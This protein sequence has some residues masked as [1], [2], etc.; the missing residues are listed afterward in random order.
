MSDY[1]MWFH[2]G[3]KFIT[4]KGVKTFFD[5]NPGDVINVYNKDGELEE[6][7]VVQS[8]TMF[9]TFNVNTFNLGGNESLQPNGNLPDSQF[10]TKKEV[11]TYGE[12]LWLMYTGRFSN[13]IN[14]GDSL[15]VAP[16]NI[17][18]LCID[19]KCPE[20]FVNGG[21]LAT[22]ADYIAYIAEDI[23]EV[24][25]YDGVVERGSYI[26]LN[27]DKYNNNKEFLNSVGLYGTYYKYKPSYIPIPG[28]LSNQVVCILTGDERRARIT[29]TME[30]NKC[31]DY[32]KAD[33]FEGYL[34]FK[35][36]TVGKDGKIYIREYDSRVAKFV[37]TCSDY[38]GY[39]I[40][41]LRHVPAK[42]INAT[43]FGTKE[44]YDK[45]GHYHDESTRVPLLNGGK[46]YIR[47]AE[48]YEIILE[49]KTIRHK[50]RRY[51]FTGRTTEEAK[52][53]LIRGRRH[54]MKF[55]YNIKT[56]SGSFILANGIIAITKPFEPIV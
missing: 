56:E 46:K 25:V 50:N 39:R 6:G 14:I 34:F 11:R 23:G 29:N 30:W 42:Y 48:Y 16:K 19:L 12:D 18:N 5:V 36:H 7:T 49:P 3:T 27:E 54:N 24:T 9:N 2:K 32:Y 21:V 35:G 43:G 33:A 8:G 1:P 55:P 22:G 52:D 20:W 40:T 31:P 17:N 38:A 41:L 44:H 51:V 15:R 53:V 13:S 37:Q 47:E 26:I 45:E 10:L 4:D 28:M